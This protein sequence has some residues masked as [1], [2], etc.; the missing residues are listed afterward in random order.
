MSLT[1][2]IQYEE[3]SV[4][5]EEQLKIT[6]KEL[7]NWKRNTICLI[8]F[9]V[10]IIIGLSIWGCMQI[11][12]KVVAQRFTLVDDL[13][14][15]R[16][17]LGMVSGRNPA[18]IMF[19]SQGKSCAALG[20]DPNGKTSLVMGGGQGKGITLNISI[21][22]NGTPSFIMSD[23]HGK[24]RVILGVTQEGFPTLSMRDSQGK[25]RLVLG[26]D[27]GVMPLISLYDAEEN[28]RLSFGVN[29]D[30]NP[31]FWMSDAKG[32]TIWSAP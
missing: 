31:K 6:Q 14:K 1:K 19:D 28:H 2:K 11:K 18:L 3:K 32:K 9:A 7:N 27:L 30:G 29:N 4:N 10:L 8:A 12:K 13:G 5:I 16:A 17:A 25:D 20:V 24:E 21:G 15:P 22:L 26:L 23:S